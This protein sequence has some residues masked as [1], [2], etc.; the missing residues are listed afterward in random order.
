[1]RHEELVSV[2]LGFKPGNLACEGLLLA[3][4]LLPLDDGVPREVAVLVGRV[5][6]GSQQV[7]GKAVPGREQGLE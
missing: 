4:M 7:G 1:M 2:A 6:K 3:P 5:G